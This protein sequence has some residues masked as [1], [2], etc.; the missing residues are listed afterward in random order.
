MTLIGRSHSEFLLKRQ[1]CR[2]VKEELL[3]IRDQLREHR[4]AH[5]C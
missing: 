3:V 4:K 5:K 2:D 1:E